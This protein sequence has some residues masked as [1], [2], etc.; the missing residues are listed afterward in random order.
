MF[1]CAVPHG[2]LEI[3]HSGKHTLINDKL[4][5]YFFQIHTK[6]PWIA[7]VTKAIAVI[8]LAILFYTFV[9]KGNGSNLKIFC[10]DMVH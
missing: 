8:D 2:H 6:M 1:V 3:G 4:Y 5:L 7:K 10:L 9:I